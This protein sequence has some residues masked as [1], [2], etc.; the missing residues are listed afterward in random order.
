[1]LIIGE[2][3]MGRWQENR[4][5]ES[6]YLLNISVNLTLLKKIKFLIKEIVAERVVD[7]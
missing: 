6:L 3:G 5:M 7:L 2:K 4:K 1:M